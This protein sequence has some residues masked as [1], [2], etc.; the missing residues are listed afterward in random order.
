MQKKDDNDDELIPGETCWYGDV[1]KCKKDDND[2]E[3]I[4]GETC[5]KEGEQF[6][7][8]TVSTTASGMTCDTWSYKVTNW[9]MYDDN[10]D[11]DLAMYDLANDDIGD[12][13]AGNYCRNYNENPNGPYCFVGATYVAYEDVYADIKDGNI[14]STQDHFEYCDIPKCP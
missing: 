5:W 1:P 11:Y 14:L 12:G 6:M 10:G 8:T 3:L 7:G 13:T 4:P 2:D 9:H